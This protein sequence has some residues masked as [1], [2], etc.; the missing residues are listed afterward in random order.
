MKKNKSNKNKSQQ[1]EKQNQSEVVVEGT[2][3]EARPNAMFDV[4]LDNDQ[5]IL[6]TICGKIRVN[7]I[8]ILP[9]DRVE[10]GLSV[11][12]MTHGRILFRK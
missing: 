11:Y 1:S 2:V 4:K 3:I 10:L 6:C 7:R 8:R 12:D 9:G 5:V